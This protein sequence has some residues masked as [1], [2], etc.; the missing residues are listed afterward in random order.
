[1]SWGALS[2]LLGDTGRETICHLPTVSRWGPC[3]FLRPHRAWSPCVWGLVVQLPALGLVWE[4]GCP[5]VGF[6]GQRVRLPWR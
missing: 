4:E 6:H 3:G 5:G 2:N 1:M